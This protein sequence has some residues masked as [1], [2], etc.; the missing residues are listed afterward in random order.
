MTL[1][2]IGTDRGSRIFACSVSRGPIESQK[3]MAFLE[4]HAHSSI[5]ASQHLLECCCIDVQKN[6]VRV[7]N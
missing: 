6:L 7:M 1:D 3:M 4:R 5:F 2:Q